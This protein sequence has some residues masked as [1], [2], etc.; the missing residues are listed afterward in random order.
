MAY[1]RRIR[2]RNLCRL[3][4]QFRITAIRLDIPPRPTVLPLHQ[5]TRRNVAVLIMRPPQVLTRIVHNRV[6]VV[7]ETGNL[8]ILPV[9]VPAHVLCEVG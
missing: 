1:T 6:D 7:R 5:R 9:A 3:R 2:I 8:L 4:D